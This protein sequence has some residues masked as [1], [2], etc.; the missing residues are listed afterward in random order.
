VARPRAFECACCVGDPSRDTTAVRGEC[1]PRAATSRGPQSRL[2]RVLGR[3]ASACGRH[4][5]PESTRRF[6]IASSFAIVLTRQPRDRGDIGWDRGGRSL[7]S[8]EAAPTRQDAP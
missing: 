3:T 2:M 4:P 1:W 7:R 5:S 6:T 8:G